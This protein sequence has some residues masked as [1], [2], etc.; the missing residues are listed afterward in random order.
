MFNREETNILYKKTNNSKELDDN[1]I[2]KNVNYESI[3]FNPTYN[4]LSFEE[5]RLQQLNKPISTTKPIYNTIL[6]TT[7]PIWNNTILPTTQ[8]IYNTSLPT[9]KPIWNNTILP[10]TQSIYNT[11]LPATKPIW[12]NTS[13]PTTK[14]IWNNTSLPTTQSI[15][16]NTS[17]P[18]TVSNQNTNNIIAPIIPS[19]NLL[20]ESKQ[21]TY[22]FQQQHNQPI[23]TF[24]PF[25]Q[26][27]QIK[28]IELQEQ[29]EY[30][31]DYSYLT[32]YYRPIIKRYV[33]KNVLRNKNRNRNLYSYKENEIKECTWLT[34][35][36]DSKD[37]VKCTNEKVSC[38]PSISDI[39]KMSLYELEN[40]S[41][42]TVTH[43]IYGS[44]LFNEPINIKG[45]N[46]DADIVFKECKCTL[47][48]ELSNKKITFE[49]YNV[50][51][52][53]KD[54]TIDKFTNK[55]KKMC[56]KQNSTFISYNNGIWKFIKN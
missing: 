27:N 35:D 41:N 2:M 17:L 40:I 25:A 55:L 14:P 38:D 18:A 15:W 31:N 19:T 11:S 32:S 12:N 39:S 54:Q 28:T 48:P 49:F 50:F 37:H 3:T 36:L 46:I 33:R 42:F 7:K 24:D 44:V 26:I 43:E 52:K 9:T 5:L 22:F 21:P 1:G 4:N 45:L 53:L 51:P 8:S 29:E 16:N 56:I 47:S 30:I 10:T 6:P 20:P 34:L 13:L 23:Q